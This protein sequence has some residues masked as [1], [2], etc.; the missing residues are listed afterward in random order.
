MSG[1]AMLESEGR[2]SGEYKFGVSATR[3]LVT[4]ITVFLNTVVSGVR[5][6]P[7]RRKIRLDSRYIT[8]NTRAAG[9]LG[10]RRGRRGGAALLHVRI[11]GD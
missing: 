11:V 9:D 3:K 5:R 4:S 2:I 7:P 1:S 6:G 8:F 10:E